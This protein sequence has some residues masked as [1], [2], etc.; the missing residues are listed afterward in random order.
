MAPKSTYC[1]IKEN[2]KKEITRNSPG[3]KLY[4]TA[5]THGKT[6]VSFL[7]E[8]ISLEELTNGKMDL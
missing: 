2:R 6:V 1:N 5:I 7:T 4:A 8:N 3:K